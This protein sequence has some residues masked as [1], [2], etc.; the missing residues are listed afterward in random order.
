[1]RTI[2]EQLFLNTSQ[3]LIFRLKAE[4]TIKHTRKMPRA[5]EEK[6]LRPLKNSSSTKNQKLPFF[7]DNDILV[8]NVCKKM[9]K[10]WRAEKNSTGPPAE[11]HCHRPVLPKLFQCADHFKY[12]STLL[13]LREVQNV[14]VYRD[15]RTT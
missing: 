15:S 13:V 14:D 5:Y 8:N 9:R 11:K 4:L 7:T 1:M 3:Q 12:F 2:I 6:G 10:D